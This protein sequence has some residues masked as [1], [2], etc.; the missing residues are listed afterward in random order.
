[1]VQGTR[2]IGLRMALGAQPR[3]VL[4]LVVGHGML[5]AGAGVA[6]GLA[7][8]AAVTRVIKNLL[9]GVNAID[10]LTFGAVSLLLVGVAFVACLIPAR[11]ATKVDPMIALRHE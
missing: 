7:G 6:L 11:H 5:L 9:F 1:V 8:A 3:D 4:K 10:P 2:E